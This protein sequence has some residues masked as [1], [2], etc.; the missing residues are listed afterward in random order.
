MT[1]DY[2]A[3]YYGGQGDCDLYSETSSIGGGAVSETGWTVVS[4]G[5]QSIATTR[6]NASR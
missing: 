6:T 1:I 4:E 5:V 2:T 3:Q